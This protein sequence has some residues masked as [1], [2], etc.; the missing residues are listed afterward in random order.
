MNAYNRSENALVLRRKV[1]GYVAER[2]MIRARLTRAE[3]VLANA[4]KKKSE[5]DAG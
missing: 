4:R 1:D 5:I 3:C 2:N